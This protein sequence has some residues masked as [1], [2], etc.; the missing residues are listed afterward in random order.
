MK[1]PNAPE[2]P[3][4]ITP[5]LKAAGDA[6]K[7]LKGLEAALSFLSR[8]CAS[9]IGDLDQ[10]LWFLL[11]ERRNRAEVHTDLWR[12][13][14][15]RAAEHLAVLKAALPVLREAARRQDLENRHQG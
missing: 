6:E 2:A 7:A 11:T 13:E 1:D 10:G 9:A 3:F 4:T 12:Q 14:D 5:H 8:R 15:A